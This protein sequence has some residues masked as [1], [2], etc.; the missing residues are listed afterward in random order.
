L[1]EEA[2]KMETLLQT[3]EESLLTHVRP[4]SVAF[5]FYELL[6]EAGFDDEEIAEVASAM[7]DIVSCLGG[8]CYG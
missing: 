8:C 4:V 2:E 7:K 3:L 5:H 1:N 6:C